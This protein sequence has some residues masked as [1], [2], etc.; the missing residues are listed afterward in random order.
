[1]LATFW[2]EARLGVAD[3]VRD[4]VRRTGRVDAGGRAAGE[5]RGVIEDHPLRTVE[6]EDRDLAPGRE[7]E[8]DQRA[9]GGAALVDVLLPRRRLPAAVDLGVVRGLRRANLGVRQEAVRDR[10]SCHPAQSFFFLLLRSPAKYWVERFWP[11]VLRWPSAI[12]LRIGG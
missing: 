10:V 8:R 6:P 3:D 7:A 12:S 5:H 2:D 11:L 1:L 4:L 9:G